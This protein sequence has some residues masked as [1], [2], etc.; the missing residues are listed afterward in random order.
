MSLRLS[1][2][3]CLGITCSTAQA[4]SE[5]PSAEWCAGG[6]PREVATFSFGPHALTPAPKPPRDSGSTCPAAAPGRPAAKNCGDFDD[7]YKRGFDASK[8]Y[9]DG[10]KRDRV[11]GEVA[12]AGSVV[13]LVTTPA[14]FLRPSHHADY[15]VSE[16]LNGVC[17]RCE[18]RPV[19]VPI[20]PIRVER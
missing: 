20:S 15:S 5:L 2:V 9:C 10:F 8:S 11:A 16:G 3:L 17:V 4:H 6:H 19:V 1:F 7:D 13:A 12:D 14:S 18:S